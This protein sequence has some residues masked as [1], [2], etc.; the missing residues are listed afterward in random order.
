MSRHISQVRPKNE[1]GAFPYSPQR[2][3]ANIYLPL[4]REVITGMDE[5]FWDDHWRYEFEQAGVT[6]GDLG[7]TVMLFSESLARFIRDPSIDSPHTA[8]TVTGFMDTPRVAR[9]FLFSRLGSVVTGG[10]FVGIRDVTLGGV[11][12][13]VQGQMVEAVA[14]ARATARAMCQDDLIE[15]GRA[16]ANTMSGHPA[17]PQETK[18]TEAD[19]LYAELEETKKTLRQSQEQ[20]HRQMTDIAELEGRLNFLR[21]VRD[22]AAELPGLR[23]WKRVCTV[24]RLAWQAYKS[25]K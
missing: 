23:Y 15:A 24:A 11:T 14:E 13:P 8:F 7:K 9:E 21:P 20:V 12:S 1:Q 25:F 10:F 19:H 18:G 22:I 2:D 17:E 6:E 16:V 3:L 5:K 4:Y